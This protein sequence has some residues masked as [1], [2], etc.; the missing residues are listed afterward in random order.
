MKDSGGLNAELACNWGCLCYFDK[1][2]GYEVKVK[3]TQ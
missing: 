2:Q 1:F 3:K